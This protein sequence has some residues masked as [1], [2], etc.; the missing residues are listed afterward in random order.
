MGGGVACYIH[1]SLKARLIATSAATHINAPE[2]L[3]I[4]IR[5][6]CNETVLFASVY[7]RP[8]GF[9]LHDFAQALTNVSHLYKNIIIG[10]DLNCNLLTNSFEANFLRD[11]MSGLSMSIIQSDATYHTATSDSWLDVLAVDDCEKV[12]RFYK[13]EC[14][15]IAGHDLI[16]LSLSLGTKLVA[17]RTMLRRCYRA[18]D[19][20]EF[21]DHL[22]SLIESPEVLACVSA[23]SDCGNVRCD[24]SSA[25]LVDRF[26]SVLSETVLNTLD[27][28]A[29]ERVFIIN[30]PP[31]RWL[32][33]DLKSRI[34]IRNQVYKR[35]KRSNSILGYFLYRQF[36]NQLNLDI[37]RAKSEFQFNSLKTITDPAKLWRELARL[38]LVKSSSVS[39]LHYFTPSQLN[40]HYVSVSDAHSPCLYE[41]FI[42]AIARVTC[43]SERPEFAFS[44]IT[45]LTI[46]QLI[47]ARPLHSY[48]AGV[49]GIPLYI[50]RLA[51]PVISSCLTALF[52]YSLE[53]SSFPSQWKRALIRPLS[54]TRIPS[55]PSDTR[56]I[57]NLPELSKILERIVASQIADYLTKLNLINT[58]QSA[59]RPYHNTQSALLR[60][61]DDIKKAIDS[62]LVTIMILFDFSKAFDT[63]PHLR[64][65]IK[66]KELGFS[67][68]TLIWLF[69][70]LTGRSQAVADDEGNLSSWLITLCGVPQGSVLGPPLFTLYINDIG[71]VLIY[72]D[73]MIFA[74][75]VQIYRSCALSNLLH[76]LNLISK[77]ANAIFDY[78]NVNGLK[79][80]PA[81]SKVIIFGSGININN[82][83][84]NALPPI[85]VNHT[86]LPY[87]SEVRNLGV[88]FE[89]NLSWNKHVSHVSQRVHH[90]LYKLKFSKNSLSTELRIKLVTSLV[91]PHLDYCC[92]VYHGLSKELNLKLQRL[93]NCCIRFIFNLR[94]DEHITQYR[95]RLGWLSVENRRLYFLGC[96]MYRIIYMGSPA[97]LSELFTP[98]SPSLRRSTRIAN[99]SSQTFHIPAFRTEIYRNSFLISA[100]YFWHSL[101]DNITS[102]TTIAA[103]KN[104]LRS[105]LLSS[106]FSD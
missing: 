15:F 87:V 59:F 20:D 70:Y 6:P 74:D 55:S 45:P 51:W 49:N 101:P 43:P 95:R 2:F 78:A 66:L 12:L 29:P 26:C 53:Q 63:V 39:P 104:L 57:A 68:P 77:D 99:C 32:T 44:A 10:G 5:L 1:H 58:R 31:V 11:L 24:Q 22:Q 13:S 4:E 64:L 56:P 88:C 16:E 46:F 21:L 17:E 94:K 100:I 23:A 85:I 97:Y 8:K 25:S 80:N 82:I 52:N 40:A 27:V 36:C 61:C 76:N 37:K 98:L 28:V 69:S 42:S 89:S 33:S 84:L 106:E 41:D 105:Y 35:A 65:L 48:A 62:G 92:L 9:L 3:M 50:L 79:L 93:V 103:F 102:A 30:K 81:K 47:S 73:Y 72:S 14:P 34:R 86:P 38:G 96:Q 18:I 75:D 90:A 71:T 19:A 83:D 54:K 67:D 7:R 60:V 91:L